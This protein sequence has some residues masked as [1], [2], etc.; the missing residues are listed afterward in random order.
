MSVSPLCCDRRY[1]RCGA[2]FSSARCSSPW[3]SAPSARFIL[4]RG[5]RPG[6]R[7]LDSRGPLPPIQDPQVAVS[8]LSG[9]AS[10]IMTVVSIVFA[11]LLMTLTL[12]S[13]QFS[14]RILRELRPRPGHT[15]DPRHIP[16]HLF[17]LHGRS[18]VGAVVAEALRSGAD[19]ADR[20]G[21]RAGLRRLADFLHQSHFA[22]DQRQ[23]HCRPHRGRSSARHL[24]ADA[25]PRGSHEG[26]EQATSPRQGK[27][28]VIVSRKSGYVRFI[29]VAFLVECAKTFGVE[30]TL[31][32]RAGHFVPAGAPLLRVVGPAAG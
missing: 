24:P 2:D 27:E 8:I 10:S 22:L 1:T 3:S 7:R 20:D 19:G 4:R 6:T 25:H 29:D 28:R 9:I 18:A 12:A 11:I 26:S 15:V 21:A 32:R 14:P 16:R 30:I 31:D 17:L 5:I 13:T 23:P